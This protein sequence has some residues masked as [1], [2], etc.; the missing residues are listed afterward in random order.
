MVEEER[1]PSSWAVLTTSV[2][3]GGGG[4]LGE[5]LAGLGQPAGGLG[6][7]VGGTGK[8]DA[9]QFADLV[10]R[11]AQQLGGFFL[12]RVEQAHQGYSSDR[13]CAGG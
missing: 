5:T 12:Q 8:V 6:D 7:L 11:A 10:A 9:G 13:S 2:L 4:V 3:T 1:R